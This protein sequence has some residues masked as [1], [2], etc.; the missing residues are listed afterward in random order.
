MRPG[1]VRIDMIHD[2]LEGGYQHVLQRRYLEIVDRLRR[3]YPKEREVNGHS[4][5]SNEPGQC[6]DRCSKQRAHHAGA[7]GEQEGD[8]GNTAGNRVQDHDIGQAIC[9]SGGRPVE[10]LAI[11][12]GH[13]DGRFVANSA[14]AAVVLVGAAS[15]SDTCSYTI[16]CYFWEEVCVL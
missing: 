15:L 13:D 7:Y 2:D 11:D 14:R 4:N 10:A 8:E 6:R 5:Q 12:L 3:T 9:R 16:V 1:A